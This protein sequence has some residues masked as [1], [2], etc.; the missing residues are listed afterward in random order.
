MEGKIGEIFLSFLARDGKQENLRSTFFWNAPRGW[1]LSL[2]RG[3]VTGWPRPGFPGLGE[4][5][6]SARVE[7]GSA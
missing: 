5:C 6:Q 4:R 2:A 1:P 7:P 3:I